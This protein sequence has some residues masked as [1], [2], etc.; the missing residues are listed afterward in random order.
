MVITE[1][2]KRALSEVDTILSSIPEEIKNKIPNELIETIAEEKLTE[3]NPTIENIMIE[4]N[5]KPEA[6]A[7]LGLIYRDFLSPDDIKE[8]LKIQDDIEFKAFQQLEE[9][10]YNNI[11]R[12]NRIDHTNSIN[13]NNA[14]LGVYKEKWYTKFLNIFRRKKW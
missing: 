6:I 13:Q 9:D 1:N 8:S 5:I 4:K 14:S 11:F 2:Y 3:Y 7:L 12:Y 10:K